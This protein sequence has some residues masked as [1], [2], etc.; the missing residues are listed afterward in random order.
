MT[1][2][3]VD[4]WA[5]CPTLHQGIYGFGAEGQGFVVVVDFYFTLSLPVVMGVRKNV[6]K[7]DFSHSKVR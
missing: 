7:F 2:G 5:T 1:Q 3:F 6:V 4:T